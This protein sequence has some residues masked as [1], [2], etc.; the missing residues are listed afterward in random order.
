MVCQTVISLTEHK[1][2]QLELIKPSDL[3]N[4]VLFM[5]YFD[6]EHSYSNNNM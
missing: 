1:E 4:L 3:T 6:N 2:L 5:S